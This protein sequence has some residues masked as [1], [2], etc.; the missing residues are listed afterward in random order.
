MA[1]GRGGGQ[2]RVCI[3]SPSRPPSPEEETARRLTTSSAHLGAGRVGAEPGC[4]RRPA[5]LGSQGVLSGAHCVSCLTSPEA[6]A[7][8]VPG[9]GSTTRGMAPSPACCQLFP[10][11]AP[12]GTQGLLLPL[13][14]AWLWPQSWQGALWP[15]AGCPPLWAWSQ[16]APSVQ[17]AG[18][19]PALRDR[20]GHLCAGA[21]G[22]PP[23]GPLWLPAGSAR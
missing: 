3:V 17:T 22:L 15:Q 13:P 2:D 19:S 7:L 10:W 5:Q 6:A 14:P 1:S 4:P 8:G 18:R 9:P 21:G 23:R 16:A 20:P 12:L 11:G